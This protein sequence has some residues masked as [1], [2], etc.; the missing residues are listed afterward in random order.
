MFVLGIVGEY[1][2]RMHFRIMDKPPYIVRE[3]HDN[4][5]EQLEETQDKPV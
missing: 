5:T 4:V 1:L 2:A 3:A